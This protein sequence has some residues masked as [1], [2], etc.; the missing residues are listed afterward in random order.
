[1]W[2]FSA[3][4]KDYQTALA[5]HPSLAKAMQFYK[6]YASWMEEWHVSQYAMEFKNQV[7]ELV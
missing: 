7:I 1:L 6:D 5:N 2:D 3:F 4:A